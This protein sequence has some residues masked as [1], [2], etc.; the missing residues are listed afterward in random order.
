V[1]TTRQ[2]VE[3]RLRYDRANTRQCRPTWGADALVP[4][5][6]AAFCLFAKPLI[7]RPGG[8]D[9]NI[10]IGDALILALAMANLLARRPDTRLLR[11]LPP[12]LVAAF[13]LLLSGTLVGILGSLGT[14]K[15]LLNP[16]KEA[17]LLVATLSLISLT[18]GST[19]RARACYKYLAAATIVTTLVV[20]SRPSSW[21]YGRYSGRFLG[22]LQ[23]PN[24]AGH[25]YGW[26][27]LAL[28]GV[29]AHLPKPLA[30]GGILVGL[31]G[32]YA[33]GS[34]GSRLSLAAGLAAGAIA[35]PLPRR[36]RQMMPAPSVLC[37]VA[38][39][40]AWLCGAF[41]IT[42]VFSSESD[43][44]QSVDP[45]GV[46]RI[47][48]SGP[49]TEGG[50]L[51]GARIAWAGIQ[52]TPLGRSD[53]DLAAM[54]GIPSNTEA[55]ND[56]LQVTAE[57]GVLGGAGYLLLWVGLAQVVSRLVARP[58]VGS[59]VASALIGQM[60]FMLLQTFSVETFHFRSFWVWIALLI[61]ELKTP[62]APQTPANAEPR[63][64]VRRAVSPPRQ[65]SD[66]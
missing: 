27:V 44:L 39:G 29:I 35:L 11:G 28:L 9:L 51:R 3:H 58:H 59:V 6:F 55:H 19:A 20:Y 2:P 37:T 18:A 33:S 32:V 52:R 47:Q 10:T 43:V 34:V 45:M 4:L 13:A 14:T 12:V 50:R 56:L 31:L 46:G 15:A 54:S 8:V 60:V 41:T 61:A 57:K 17:W 5:A 23:D 66:R 16:G 65:A 42:G 49:T 1:T 53:G 36:A 24:G 38:I 7:R 21:Y 62:E 30:L 25:F 63:P 40:V 26:L 64:R 22:T 48:A